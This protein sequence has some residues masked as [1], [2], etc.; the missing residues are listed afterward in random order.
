[1]FK[2][3]KQGNNPCIEIGMFDF[4]WMDTHTQLGIPYML[5][6][7]TIRIFFNSRT[8]GKT[9]PTYV[10]L[11]NSF[12]IVNKN[13]KPL[14]ELGRRGTFDDCGVMFSSIVDVGNKIYMYYTGWNEMKSVRY[15][16]S[17]GLAISEDGGVTFYKFSDGPIMDRSIYNPIMVA[18]PYVIRKSPSNWIMYYLSCSEWIQGTVKVEPVYDLHYAISQDG[19]Y[20][21]IPDDSSCI[22]GNNEAIAQPCVI[23]LNGI[24]HMFYSYRKANDYRINRDNSYRIGYAKSNDAIKWERM[25]ELV[26]ID[27]SENGWD[28]EMIEYPYVVRRNDKLIMFYNGNGFGQSGIGCAIANIRNFK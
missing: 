4:G 22:Q 9:R 19:I 23:E 18:G 26:G 7:N 1:M 21:N 27:V 16:N 10:D 17:I 11:D 5:D 8:G 28:S 12:N 2:W 13:E 20:W 24:Y 14:L 15:H 6:E 3:K 25:D